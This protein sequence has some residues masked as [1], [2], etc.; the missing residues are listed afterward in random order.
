MCPP[1]SQAV[2]TASIDAVL[3]DGVVRAEGESSEHMRTLLR[4]A[5]RWSSQ[6]AEGVCGALGRQRALRVPFRK[7]VG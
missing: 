1:Q 7:P 2:K 4:R 6:S 3:P 5:L